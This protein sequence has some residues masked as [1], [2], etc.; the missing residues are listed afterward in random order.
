MSARFKT[1]RLQLRAETDRAHK[2]LE[3]I[4]AA[5]GL[6]G[7][8]DDYA[9]LLESFLR[10][11]RPLEASLAKLDWGPLGLNVTERNKSQWLAADLAILGRDPGVIE[12]WPTIPRLDTTIRGLGAL[13]VVE[14]ASLGGQVINK[15]LSEHLGIGPATG[16]R[17]FHSYGNDVSRMWRSY[18]EVLESAA[19]EEFDAEIMTSA[20]LETFQT[21]HDC[22]A[23]AAAH[24]RN[25]VRGFGAAAE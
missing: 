6:T 7:R 8:R 21:F 5:T 17:F 15:W 22:L 16:G 24:Q 23:F 25:V 9:N 1:F 18:L 14:G 11:Y 4:L 12:D 2:T 20:A 19:T 3:A 13:Y 10:I